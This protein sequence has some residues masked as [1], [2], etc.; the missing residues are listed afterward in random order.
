MNPMSHCEGVVDTQGFT[1]IR[2]FEVTRSVSGVAYNAGFN[3]NLYPRHQAIPKTHRVA[4][5]LYLNA[6]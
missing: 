4:R 6:N 1:H 2:E 3:L 5:A